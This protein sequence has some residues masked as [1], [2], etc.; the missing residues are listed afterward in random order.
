MPK[1]HW[2]TVFAT[3]TKNL[4]CGSIA[5]PMLKDLTTTKYLFLRQA[6]STWIQQ[7]RTKVKL[8]FNKWPRKKNIV[9]SFS[10]GDYFSPELHKNHILLISMVVFGFLL[11]ICLRGRIRAGIAKICQ[12]RHASLLAPLERD[13]PTETEASVS[14]TSNG[15]CRV[16]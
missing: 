3:Q 7:D 2:I 5:F 4:L 13:R 8:F 15:A 6:S 10:P 12:I 16:V 11:L 14:Y 1:T 9:C